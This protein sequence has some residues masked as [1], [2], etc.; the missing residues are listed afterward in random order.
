MPLRRTTRLMVLLAASALLA[1]LTTPSYA[2]E[3]RVRTRAEGPAPT[4]VTQRADDGTKVRR[5]TVEWQGDDTKQVKSKDVVIPGI[6]T[7]TMTCKPNVTKVELFTANRHYETQ[8]WMAKYEKKNEREVVA[9]KNA[10]IYQY[11]HADDDGS[12]GT[13]FRA[14]EGLNQRAGQNGVENYSS[15]YLHGVISQRPG[16]GQ[17]QDQDQA[18]KP[19]TSFELNWYW[20]GFDHPR[21][22]HYCK[23]DAVFTTKAADRFVLTWHGEDDAPTKQ[24]RTFRLPGIGALTLTCE[25]GQFGRQTVSMVPDSPDATVYYEKIQ[26]EGAVDNHVEKH[27]DVEYDDEAGTLGETDLPTNGMMRL[28]YTAGENDRWIILSSLIKANDDRPWRNLCE[29]AAGVI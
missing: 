18:A 11:A 12:G 17:D 10:R 26:G 16:R 4:M 1:G 3:G 14:Q 23:L 29:L 13:G 25:P 6:G 27:Y 8:M 20:N 21:P 15:G 9:V 24:Q 28:H 5:V 19:V 2:D 7:L 22:F